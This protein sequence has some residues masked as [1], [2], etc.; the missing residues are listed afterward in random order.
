MD[1]PL[2]CRTVLGLLHSAARLALH[3]RCQHRVSCRSF[4]VQDG[5]V[6]FC[7]LSLLPACAAGGEVRG[8]RGEASL[9]KLL[10]SC[11]I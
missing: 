10:L 4:R 2:S 3:G 9:A 7:Q 6:M 11:D 8:G 1:V 5:A